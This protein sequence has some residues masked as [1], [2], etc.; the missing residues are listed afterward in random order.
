MAFQFN[1][2]YPTPA[3]FVKHMA[4]HQ[5]DGAVL[6]ALDD[7][8]AGVKQREKVTLVVSFV[9]EAPGGTLQAEVLQI[10]AAGVAVRLDDPMDAAVLA[11]GAEAAE[12][13]TPP[14]VT[15]EDPKNKWVSRRKSGPLSWS[16]DMLQ[17]EWSGLNMAE[18][19]RVAK[20][21]DRSARGLVLKKG[22]KPLQAVLMSNPKITP[23]EVG[24][25]VGKPGL[26]ADL[27]RRISASREWTRHLSV[28]RALVANP[29]MPLPVV[30]RLLRQMDL[31]ELRRLKR[32]GRVRAIV[33]KEAEKQ[34][35]RLTGKRR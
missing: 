8:E 35:A 1:L 9:N 29:N 21:G 17:S 6:I 18:K 27:L 33:K 5:A 7:G 23:N 2:Q 3:D 15:F 28:M 14:A 10:I 16:F 24:I 32:S 4:D 34:I 12:E 25:L 31:G 11:G 19:A 30:T 20:W 13:G 22:D 26:S